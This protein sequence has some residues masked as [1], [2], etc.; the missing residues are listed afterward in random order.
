MQHLLLREFSSL[1]LFLSSH[2]AKFN[3]EILN[4]GKKLI[5]KY[6]YRIYLLMV[7][8]ECHHSCFQLWRPCAH[9]SALRPANFTE[10]FRGF[11]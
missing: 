11:S 7:A 10:V 1:F 8:V 9:M 6:Q 3:K 4:T 5:H 2:R